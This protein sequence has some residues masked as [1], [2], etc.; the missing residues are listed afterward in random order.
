MPDH[1]IPMK[2][3]R[4]ILRRYGIGEDMSLGK[5]SHTGFFKKMSLGVATYAVPTSRK[6]VL[7]CYIKACRLRFEL[8]EEDGVSD[9]EF[10]GE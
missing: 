10:Y 5:G 1:S 7:V 3:L 2:K 4:K 6:S 9:E 8:R